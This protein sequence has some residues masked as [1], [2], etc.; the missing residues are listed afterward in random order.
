MPFITIQCILHDSAKLVLSFSK[1]V[2]IKERGFNFLGEPV[3][4]NSRIIWS[5]L[6]YF[7]I[8][9]LKDLKSL[10]FI[11]I[12]CILHDP[13]VLSSGFRKFLILKMGDLISLENQFYRTTELFCPPLIISILKIQTTQIFRHSLVFNGFYMVKQSFF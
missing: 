1:F 6:L 12:Q 13:A 10:S 2:Q 4:G 3:L 8:E 9:I 5:H 7:N 11:S